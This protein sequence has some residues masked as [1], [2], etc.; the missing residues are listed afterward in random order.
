MCEIKRVPEVPADQDMG[1]SRYVNM[2]VDFLERCKNMS[3]NV[4]V[5]T[6]MPPDQETEKRTPGRRPHGIVNYPKNSIGDYPST[7]RGS[8]GLRSKSG[9]DGDYPTSWG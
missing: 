6:G 8:P 3:P 2:L 1:W 9:S 5:A 7:D 4:P